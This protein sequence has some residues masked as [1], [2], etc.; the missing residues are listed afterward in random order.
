M[1][2]GLVSNLLGSPAKRGIVRPVRRS[3]Q[4]RPGLTEGPALPKALQTG[5][6]RLE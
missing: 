2:L 3:R 6:N 5:Q 4:G 1:L